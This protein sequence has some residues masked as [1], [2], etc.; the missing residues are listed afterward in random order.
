MKNKQK[1]DPHRWTAILTIAENKSEK[2]QITS[3]LT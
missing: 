2:F 3:F 1:Y